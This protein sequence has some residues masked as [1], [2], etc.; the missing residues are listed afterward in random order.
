LR[1]IIGA[2]FSALE[3]DTASM[4]NSVVGTTGKSNSMRKLSFASPF[5]TLSGLIL[6]GTFLAV[7][8]PDSVS[9]SIM[10]EL[11]K[12]FEN[13]V[14]EAANVAWPQRLTCE[15]GKDNNSESLFIINHPPQNTNRKTC[16]CNTV[17][18]S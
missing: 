17:Q 1:S 13:S 14:C 2:E 9:N 10:S 15:W 7:R 3:I 12:P 4:E 8:I 11:T 5:E 18:Y 6:S 16:I